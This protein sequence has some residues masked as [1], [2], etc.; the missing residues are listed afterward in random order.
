MLKL[1]S[2]YNTFIKIKLEE[3]GVYF[4]YYVFYIGK[5]Q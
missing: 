2:E 3:K 4:I 5:E 1:F